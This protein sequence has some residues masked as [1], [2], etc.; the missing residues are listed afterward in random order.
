MLKGDYTMYNEILWEILP[1]ALGI[2]EAAG[3]IPGPSIL[4]YFYE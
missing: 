2:A 1:N 3:E 4:M